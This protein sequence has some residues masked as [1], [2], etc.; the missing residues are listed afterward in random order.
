MGASEEAIATEESPPSWAESWRIVWQVRTLRRIFA[1]L[2]FLAL[3]IVGLLTLGSLFYQEIF[4]L[5]E[6]QRG[7]VAAVAEPAQIVGFII[8]IPIAT[9]LMARDPGLVL[10]FLAAVT[11]LVALTWIVFS[12]APNLPVAIGSNL[13]ISG[14][15]GLLAPGIYSVLSLAVPPKV[16]AF[17]F[18]IAA[19]WI[20]PGLLVLPIIGGVAD[21]YGIRTALLLAAPVFVVGGLILAS[22]GSQVAGDIRRVWTAAAA[23]SEAA[24]DRE[25]GRAIQE[26]EISHRRG[27]ARHRL[28]A[29]R[30][31]LALPRRRQ[32]A[33]YAR[34]GAAGPGGPAGLQN[35]YGRAT[36]G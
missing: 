20:I 1:A 12:Q 13:V 17:G 30:L 18:A 26:D 34:T 21:A 10:K 27:P 2:P 23:Q 7:I 28:P 36:H 25:H 22:A 6:V 32:V 5:N 16:R 4:G 3:S 29:R 19:I 15:L 35:P 14:A 8:G 24:Y 11:G 31:G 9:R 33:R